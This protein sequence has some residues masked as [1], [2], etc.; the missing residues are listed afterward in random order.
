MLAM[1][2]MLSMHREQR[3]VT[4]AFARLPAS[5]WMPVL[6]QKQ[7]EAAGWIWSL[8]RGRLLS[9][10]TVITQTLIDY[11]TAAALAENLVERLSPFCERI[12]VA[13]SVRRRKAHCKDIEIVAVPQLYSAPDPDDL[14]GGDK[15]FD[16]LYERV[17]KTPAFGIVQWIKTGTDEVIP[18]TIKPE[19]KY[20]RGVIGCGVVKGSVVEGVKLDLFLARAENFGLIYAIRTGSAEYS[21][22]LVTHAARIG[23][24]SIEGYLT[25]GGAPVHTPEERDV[26]DALRV[27]WIPPEDRIDEA[28][29]VGV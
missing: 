10:M 27:K 9:F 29:L 4:N 13:G 16:R 26:F 5:A 22:A 28:A 14:F 3:H 11:S 7:T 24:P 21:R 1:L 23:M 19:G 18:W 8:R 25:H 6:L 12:Q 17:H 20:W 2:S 15:L